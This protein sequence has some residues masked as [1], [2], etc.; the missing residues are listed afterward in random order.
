MPVH[1]YGLPCEMEAINAVARQR[2]L[3]VVEDACQAW[4]AEYRGR[5][6]GTLGDLACFSFQESK[7]LPS[8][9]GGAIT[10]DREELIDRCDAF[11][12]CG[13]AVGSVRGTG[14]F[15]R[16]LNFRMTQFQAAL[17]RQQVEKL[18][19]E[20]ARRQESADYLSA[21]L[22]RISG[23]SPARLPA[24]ARGV[25]HLYPFRY[26]PRQ[27]NGLSRDLLLKALAAEG[28]PGHAVYREQYF[29]GM[30]DE[31]IQSRG[32]RRLFGP[33]RLK[34]YRES[35]RELKGNRETCTMG[36]G[37]PQTVLLADRPGLDH[38][39]EAIARVQRHSGAIAAARSA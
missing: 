38:I 11:H 24:N 5:K 34:A 25:W 4:L 36:I 30:L 10:S 9:E 33:E 26:D 27:F 21:K 29:D 2:G 12:N 18:V 35:F 19:A 20:T 37:L 31:A 39:V 23:I 8:G 32:Y 7:H 3:S 14:S 28:V 13:R 1:I 15:T 6:C 17:L 22:S 16:G